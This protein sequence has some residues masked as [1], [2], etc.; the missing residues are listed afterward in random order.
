MSFESLVDKDIAS[1]PGKSRTER[2]D[3]NRH[4]SEV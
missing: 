3:I 2:D 1:Y 4:A